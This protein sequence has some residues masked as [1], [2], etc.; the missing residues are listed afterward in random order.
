MA[1][2]PIIRLQCHLIASLFQRERILR[3]RPVLWFE[4]FPNSSR[5]L[6]D[7]SM[8]FSFRLSLLKKIRLLHVHNQSLIHRPR[9]FNYLQSSC[10]P[11]LEE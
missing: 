5:H 11:M 7:E 9:N 6:P 2:P 3:L 8:Q 10:T 4:T 1:S